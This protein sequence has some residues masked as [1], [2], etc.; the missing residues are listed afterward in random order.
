MMSFAATW[1]NFEIIILNEI[2]QVEKEQYHMLS[3]MRVVE[4]KI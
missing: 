2:S 4:S 3:H 1:M